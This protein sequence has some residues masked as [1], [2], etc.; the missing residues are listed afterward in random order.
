MIEA[1]RLLL[2]AGARGVEALAT[3]CLAKESDLDAMRTAGIARIRATQ[4]V[5]GP[6]ACL[7]VARLI[8]DAICRE[9]WLRL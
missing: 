6:V 2:A 5:A 8:A 9:N 3:H 7:P 4:S 1:A